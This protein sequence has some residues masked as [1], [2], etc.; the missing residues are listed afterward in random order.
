M[1]FTEK[2]ASRTQGV[3]RTGAGTVTLREALREAVRA[4]GIGTKLLEQRALMLL[5]ELIDE[6]TGVPDAIARP[7]EIRH[8]ELVIRITHDAVRHRLSI[9]RHRIQARLN[10]AVGREVVTSIRFGR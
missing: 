10:E 6:L 5:P 9:E 8:G 4:L 1:G 3:D 7:A 2:I